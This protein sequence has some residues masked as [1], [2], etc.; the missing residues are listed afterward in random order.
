V[1]VRGLAFATK[2]PPWLARPLLMRGV[3]GG[4]GGKMPS[5]HI[6]LHSGRPQTEVGW[7]HGAVARHAVQVGVAAPVNQVL[8]DTLQAL[9]AGELD[10][11]RFRRR[12]ESLLSLLPA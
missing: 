12:P 1:P 11:G 5:L 10:K 2:L 6:D 4:R 7:L 9:A 3:A 8:S